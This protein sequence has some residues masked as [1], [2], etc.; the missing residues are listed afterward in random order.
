L[1]CGRGGAGADQNLLALRG[2]VRRLR[3]GGRAAAVE[4]DPG[5]RR[6]EQE[7]DQ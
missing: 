3:F 5:D 1:L 6:A 2:G 4:E 7:R